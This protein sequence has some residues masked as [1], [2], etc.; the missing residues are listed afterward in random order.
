MV[1]ATAGAFLIGSVAAIPPWTLRA[2]RSTSGAIA[3]EE[4][5]IAEEAVMAAAVA[6]TGVAEAID[7]CGHRKNR[8]LLICR[9]SSFLDSF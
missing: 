7:A 3:V 4:A 6:V 5:A 8:G 1:A 9:N 2:I